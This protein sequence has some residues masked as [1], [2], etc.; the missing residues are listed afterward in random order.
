M[1]LK[2]FQTVPKLATWATISDQAPGVEQSHELVA[3]GSDQYGL[4]ADNFAELAVW[5][6]ALG[7]GGNAEEP[8]QCPQ[9]LP[10]H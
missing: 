7:A 10:F 4:N 3:S 8:F 5:A 6:L 9:N 2:M 1:Q